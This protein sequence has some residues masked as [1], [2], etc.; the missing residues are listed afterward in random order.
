MEDR[1]N[2]LASLAFSKKGEKNYRPVII[3]II[4]KVD[5]V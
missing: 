4:E 1:L 3:K 2:K 5:D